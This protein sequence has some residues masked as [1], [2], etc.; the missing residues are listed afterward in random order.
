M[1]AILGLLMVQCTISAAV[2]GGAFTITVLSNTSA[3]SSADDCHASSA[4]HML[5]PSLR[6]GLAAARRHGDDAVTLILNGTHSLSVGGGGALAIDVPNLHLWG[7]PSAVIDGGG[8]ASLA[9]ISAP[10]VVIENVLFC[11]ANASAVA[12]PRAAPIVA[13]K[14]GFVFR[15]GGCADMA[16][17]NGGCLFVLHAHARVEGATFTNLYAAGEGAGGGGGAI[18]N[19]QGTLDISNATFRGCTAREGG[20][21][22][23]TT[24]ADMT[25]E[26]S[27]FE[28][29]VSNQGAAWFHYGVQGT[30]TF[31]RCT[32]RANRA[33][34]FMRTGTWSGG[35]LFTDRLYNFAVTESHFEGNFGG[36]ILTY[37]G[38]SRLD[39]RDSCFVNN[40][41]A[42]H[43]GAVANHGGIVSVSNC[44]FDGNSARE[45]GGALF[46]LGPSSHGSPSVMV[47]AGSTFTVNNTA[48]INNTAAGAMAM[49]KAGGNVTVTNHSVLIVDNPAQSTPEK[50]GQLFSGVTL[51]SLDV[52]S[53]EELSF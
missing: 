30:V 8:A 21:A 6:A 53:R 51:E 43:G 20:G 9:L 46:N 50:L 25:V 37:L 2:A 14:D 49:N 35:T 24:M 33:Y 19:D 7:N 44:S 3:S 48:G 16:G 31:S 42:S 39:L 32:F 12:D 17:V 5:C 22:I 38:Q 40:S 18:Y 23:W 4:T 29:C 26:N 45:S 41:N 52:Q 27:L 34:D 10:D 28:G 13:S 1:R 36:C 15:G 11:N 47:V